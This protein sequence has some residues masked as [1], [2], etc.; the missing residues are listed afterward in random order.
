VLIEKKISL[1][2]IIIF[3]ENLAGLGVIVATI[4]VSTFSTFLEVS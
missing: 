2:I 3:T 4:K 1:L